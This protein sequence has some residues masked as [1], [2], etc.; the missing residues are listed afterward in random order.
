MLYDRLVF[1]DFFQNHFFLTSVLCAV[2]YTHYWRNMC[3]REKMHLPDIIVGN[4]RA[5][6]ATTT[7]K[8]SLSYLYLCQGM[9]LSSSSMLPFSTFHRIK[10]A[11]PHPLLLRQKLSPESCVMTDNVSRSTID[12]LHK[13]KRLRTE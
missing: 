11:A 4:E 13:F 5:E 10:P 1:F 3:I 9:K 8:T 12:N 6:T 7:V 2:G